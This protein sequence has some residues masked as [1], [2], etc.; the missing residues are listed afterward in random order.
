MS[1]QR[2]TWLLSGSVALVAFAGSTAFAQPADRA[3]AITQA[4]SA[5]Q[6]AAP[7]TWLVSAELEPDNGSWI[8]DVKTVSTNGAR[9]TRARVN[10]FTFAMGR[11]RVD[12]LSASSAAQMAAMVAAQPG[13]TVSLSNALSTAATLAPA[14]AGLRGVE[15]ELENSPPGLFY[16]VSFDDAGVIRVVRVSA[17]APISPPPGGGGGGGGGGTGGGTDDPPGDDNGGGGGG[18][19]AGGGTGGGTDDPPGDDNGGGGGGTGGVSL[20]A[21]PTLQSAILAIATLDPAALI[22]EAKNEIRDGA[23]IYKVVIADSAGALF[24]YKISPAGAII[25]L[26]PEAKDA[27]DA[28]VIAALIAKAGS[29]GINLSGAAQQA[30]DANPGATLLDVEWEI[31][32]ARLVVQVRLRLEGAEIKVRFDAITGQPLTNTNPGPGGAGVIALGDALTAAAGAAP[33]LVA[34]EVE[35][36]TEDAGPA[37]DIRMVNPVTF[38]AQ[39]VRVDATTGDVLGVTPITLSKRDRKEIKAEIARL[40]QLVITFDAA[41]AAVLPSPNPAGAHVR[42]VEVEVH[43]GRIGYSVEVM[44]GKAKSKFFVDGVTAQV[45]RRK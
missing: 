20:G 31:E 30:A 42:S 2:S 15:F 6:A 26:E 25:E 9:Q 28:A 44:T 40:A 24:E 27:E 8:V 36:E 1:L 43:K 10:A 12:T 38:S 22:L 39:V 33:G 32:H 21:L 35:L 34:L 14:G 16:D 37:F 13:A 17:T 41:A 3:G 29:L 19:G 4:I 5:A 7:G 11:V 18:G 45:T 23:P